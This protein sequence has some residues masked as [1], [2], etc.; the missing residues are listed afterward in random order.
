MSLLSTLEYEHTEDCY[1]LHVRIAIKKLTAVNGD[2][3]VKN[4]KERIILLYS[5]SQALFRFPSTHSVFTSNSPVRHASDGILNPS[6]ETRLKR[7]DV[8][9]VFCSPRLD[10]FLSMRTH[11]PHVIKFVAD[12]KMSGFAAKSAGCVCTEAFRSGKKKLRIKKYS[13]TCGQKSLK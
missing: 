12:S 9:L 2:N 1:G 11:H 5:Y 4:S 6:E 7:F 13:D 8:I 3:A 10:T